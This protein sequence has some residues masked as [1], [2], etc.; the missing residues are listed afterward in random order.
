MPPLQKKLGTLVSVHGISPVFL[1]RAAIVAVLAFFF[2]LAMLLVFYLR[3]QIVYFVLSTA[4]LVVYIFTMIG[5]VMQR[6]NVVSIYEN[7]IAYRKFA[8]RWD[9][10]KSVVADAEWG[11]AIVKTNG[12]SA[13][14]SKTIADF[15]KI[16]VTIRKRLPG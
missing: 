15:E 4:F 13:T 12:E 8:S 3:Q 11:I 10:I 16:A 14:I 2:F 7:G 5:W 9:E 6:R 1:Q